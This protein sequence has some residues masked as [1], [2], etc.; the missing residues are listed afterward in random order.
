MVRINVLMYLLYSVFTVYN[1]HIDDVECTVHNVHNVH[2]TRKGPA[3][4]CRYVYHNV[5]YMYMC[6]SS[7][8]ELYHISTN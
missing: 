1:V 8:V 4:T 6:M 3:T 7:Y 2:D 5:V